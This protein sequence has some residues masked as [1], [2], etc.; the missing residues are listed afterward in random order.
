MTETDVVIVGAGAAGLAAAKVLAAQG[1]EFKV[2]E[3]RNRIGG[4]AWTESHTF[5]VPFDI[6]CAWL[7]AADRNPFVADARSF[8]FSLTFHD[9]ALDRVY[10]AGQAV[11][12]AEL[13]SIA[14]A[15]T[16]FCAALA[17]GIAMDDDAGALA[18]KVTGLGPLHDGIGCYLGP[19][20][21]G[22]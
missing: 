4:R 11:T 17:T 6:G 16:A 5:G 13:E 21:Y 19:M 18:R 14:A 10:Y 8:G 7:H 1:L 15:E 22:S 3:A 9:P 20:D 12:A 2:L